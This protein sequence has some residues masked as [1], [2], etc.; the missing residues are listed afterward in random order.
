MERRLASLPL[1]TGYTLRIEGQFRA[2][3]EAA[4][5]IG[6]LSLVSLTLI[7]LVLYTRYRSSAL[8]LIVMGN[9]PLALVGSVAALWLAGL[10]LS[11]AAMVGFITPDRHHRP[12]WHP[13]DQPHAEPGAARWPAFRR[14][15]RSGGPAWSA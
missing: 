1:P 9:V 3:Q 10:D 14:V 8:A 2:Q 11:I 6:L 4:R 5:M 15:K 7:F 12:Q 13:Q